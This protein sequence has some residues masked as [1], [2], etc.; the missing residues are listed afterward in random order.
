MVIWCWPLRCNPLCDM[1]RHAMIWY[2]MTR[3]DM[4]WMMR[5]PY[6]RSLLE[7][8]RLFGPSAWKVLATTYE[9][10][11]SWAT[12]PWRKSSK[13]KS[14]FGDRVYEMVDAMP[15]HVRLCGGPNLALETGRAMPASAHSR[16]KILHARSHK[17]E[18]VLENATES[19]LKVSSR[20]PL[21]TWQSFWKI[22]LTNEHPLDNAADNP[23][24]VATESP[25][26][27]LRCRFPACDILPPLLDALTPRRWALGSLSA[28]QAASPIM[29]GD[30]YIYIYTLFYLFIYIYIYICI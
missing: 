2:D 14:S 8:S 25:R 10:M 27:F 1:L 5:C 28:P 30:I 22:P 15:L 20:N 9:Q 23:S 3:H 24:G 11:G 17:S 26:W 6:T 7:D 21:G 16:G 13:R 4:K 29:S 18:I 19:P 12:S